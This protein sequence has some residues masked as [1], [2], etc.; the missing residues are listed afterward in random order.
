MTRSEEVEEK[1]DVSAEFS[2]MGEGRDGSMGRHE[3]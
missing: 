3:A 2:G 1:G